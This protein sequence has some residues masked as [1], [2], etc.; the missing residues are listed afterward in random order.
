MGLK[1]GVGDV[2]IEAR[3]KI[4]GVIVEFFD[5]RNGGEDVNVA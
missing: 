3:D 2:A 5:G 4:G 1:C